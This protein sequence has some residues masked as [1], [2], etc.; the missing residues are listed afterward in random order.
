MRFLDTHAHIYLDA[1]DEDR[2][3]IIDRASV[4]GIDRI[5]LPNIDR[6]S[7]SALHT[8]CDLYPQK[9]FPMMGLHPCSVQEDWKQVLDEMQPLFSERPYIAVG[10][11]G[12]DLHWDKSTLG[13]QQEAFR[14]Q[15]EWAKDMDLPIVIHARE[16]FPQL[17]E[18]LDEMNDD[19]LRGVFHCFTGS[20][21]QAQHIIGYGGFM[22]GIGGVAT[23][24]NTNLRDTLKAVPLE[25][26]ILET[27]SPYLAPVP[28]RGKRNEPSYLLEVAITL[29]K[30][31]DMPI[32]ELAERTTANAETLF[33]LT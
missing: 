32:T 16:S 20:L 12:I 29:S 9:C 22:M 4:N 6:E 3:K 7:I 28:F 14:V 27:D 2:D 25:H 31:Y 5:L 18:I 15:V 10:E 26:I 19:S 23:Y 13:W 11:V 21:E 17:F 30:V 24:K 1:F 8:T 33:R